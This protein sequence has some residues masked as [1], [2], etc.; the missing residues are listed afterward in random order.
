M[1]TTSPGSIET[2]MAVSR[3]GDKVI[4]CLYLRDLTSRILIERELQKTNAFFTNIIQSSVDGIV[5]VDTKG[6]PLI[7]NEGAE[8]ILGYTAEEMI[9]NP[10]NFRRFYPAEDGGGDD[11]ADAQQ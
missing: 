10:E 7:F 11:A 4:T 2:C 6:V 8:R 3:L 5:V 9:G 1:R